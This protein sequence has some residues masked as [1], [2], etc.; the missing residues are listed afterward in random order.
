[1]EA[2]LADMT[3]SISEFKDNPSKVVRQAA[4]TPFCVLS[5]NK[6]SFYVVDPE[7]WEKIQDLLDDIALAPV[8]EKAVKRRGQA[9][10]VSLSDL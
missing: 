4:Q 6:P 3:I 2:I 10:R 9:V 1:V 8:I 7:T 5:N